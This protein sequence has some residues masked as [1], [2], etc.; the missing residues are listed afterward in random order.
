VRS[1]LIGNANAKMDNV[2]E[3]DNEETKEQ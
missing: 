2:G 1:E 3:K